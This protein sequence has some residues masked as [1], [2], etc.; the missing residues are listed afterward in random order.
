M[1]WRILRMAS[2]NNLPENLAAMGEIAEF[3]TVRPDRQAMLDALP[4]C[5]GV[6][7][8]L[9]I[10]LDREAIERAPKLKVIATAS[11]GR[12][13]IDLKC[14]EERGIY[15]LSLKDDIDFLSNV[16]A[17]AE[18]AWGLLLAAV[19]HIP[20]AFDSA[21]AGRWHVRGPFRG[22]QLSGKTLGVL[23][24]GR[25][26]RMTAQYGHGFRMR[27]LACDVRK[28]VAP[29]PFVTIVDFNTLLKDSDVISIHI[30]MTD[31]NRG[32]FGPNEF[33]R[34]KK[35]AYLVNTSRGGIIQEPALI[36][37][38]ESGQLAGAGLDV[39]DGEWNPDME[40]HPLLRYARAHENLVISPHL[41]GVT[42][43]SQAM[44]GN[45]MIKK[46]QAHLEKLGSPQ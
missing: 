26:G 3:V 37:A 1:R 8:G 36:A 38:L 17:T 29:D 6:I 20:W 10:P 18:M 28:D 16:T 45:Y 22:R 24:Y 25:L 14:A 12:D 40:N 32:I 30:H 2:N 34:M 33:A 35:G 15:V 46:L 44:A 43:E 42:V 13:H 27:V 41:G 19:R 23:G 39:I 9:S 7:T 11:T 31:E 5:H 21:K 4:S